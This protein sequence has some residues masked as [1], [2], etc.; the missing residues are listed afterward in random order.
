MSKKLL[1]FNQFG[2]RLI[3]LFLL[4]PM[5]PDLFAQLVG[6]SANK[7][8]LL[9]ASILPEG[10][11]EFEPA[12]SVMNSNHVFNESWKTATQDGY[13]TSSSLDFRMTSGLTDKL[14]IGTSISSSIEEINFGAKY[15]I[16][17]GDDISLALS[18]GTS[19]PAGNKFIAD[20]SIQNENFYTASFGP[21]LSY[22]IDENN[23]FD[24]AF[25]YT[26]ALGKS[27]FTDQIYAGLGWGYSVIENLQLV[28]EVAGYACIDNEICSSK[29]SLYPGVT[30]DITQNFSFAFGFQHDL[31]GK[32]EE[33]GFGYFGAF[34]ITFD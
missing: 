17:A 10:T 6:V 1:S 14:E 33:D 21:V 31:I 9:S 3:I 7:L 19:L 4:T 24:I 32:N 27:N 2:V 13:N 29:L 18:G 12:F 25:V 28:F 16:I 23:S 30:Y 22:N 26:T 8:T 15:L 34:T 11:F 20:S 5:Y